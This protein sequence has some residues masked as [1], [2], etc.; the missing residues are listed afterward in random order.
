MEK[1]DLDHW[2]VNYNAALALVV[3]DL[4]KSTKKLKSKVK[5]L[6]EENKELKNTIKLIEERL[7][8]LENN[9]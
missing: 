3:G 1:D 7:N 5:T 6:E 4:Q 9:K 2:R 8:K